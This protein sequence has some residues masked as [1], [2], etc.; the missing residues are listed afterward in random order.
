[1]VA[2]FI[3]FQKAFSDL[4][5]FHHFPL[6]VEKWLADSYSENSAIERKITLSGIL[7][8]VVLEHLPRTYL[9]SCVKSL[10]A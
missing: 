4:F 8:Q 1:M 5:I 3:I 6:E 2:T 9:P 10:R 7:S